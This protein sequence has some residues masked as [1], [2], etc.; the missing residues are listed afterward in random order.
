MFSLS[1]RFLSAVGWGKKLSI[2]M[3]LGA[4]AFPLASCRQP[5][6]PNAQSGDRTGVSQPSGS[7]KVTVL[8][9][10]VGEQQTQLEA[11]LA[12]FEKETGIDVIY[13]GTDAFTTLLPVR[14][15]S[16]DAPDIAMFPQPGLMRSLAAEGAIVPVTEVLSRKA[17]QAYYP[18]SWI[19]LSTVNDKIYGIWYRAAVKSLVWYNPKEFAKKG[20]KIPTTW[21]EMITLSDQIVAEGGTPWCLAIEGG[22]SSGWPGTDW[23]EDILLH[24][25]GPEFYDQWVQHKVPF[26]APQVQEAFQYF[27]EIVKQPGYVYGGPTG[28]LSIP[29]G[30]SIAGL[31][32]QKTIRKTTQEPECYLQKQGN[33]ISGFFPENVVLGEDVDFFETPVINPAYGNAMLVAGDIFSMLNDTP[34]ARKLMAYLATPEPHEIWAA[35]GNFLSANKQVDLNVYP[36]VLSKKQAKLL[37]T[38]E[39]VQFDGSDG[40]PGAVGTGTFWSGIMDFVAGASAAEVTDKI[41]YYWPEDTEGENLAEVSKK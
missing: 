4:I 32:T 6:D 36:D 29:W 25:A 38:A 31:F 27:G 12:P 35:Q 16:G 18:D 19:E 26:N 34:E 41:E 1:R 13:E 5:A 24:Q 23:V 14:I 20:Y 10:F 37:T 33:F 39:I 22:N 21:D 9:A 30:D 11:A 28:A 40:M 7:N 15:D 2:G 3:I 17:L 8:G